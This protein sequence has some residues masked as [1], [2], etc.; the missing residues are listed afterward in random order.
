[1]PGIPDSGQEW[2]AAADGWRCH[3][4]SPAKTGE[5][6]PFSAWPYRE[7]DAPECL[8]N[9]FP[10]APTVDFWHLS[11]PIPGSV[12]VCH[13]A[14][15]APRAS[16]RRRS[17]AAL[18]REAPPSGLKRKLQPEEAERRSKTILQMAS[19]CVGCGCVAACQDCQDCQD[20]K[21]TTWRACGCGCKLASSFYEAAKP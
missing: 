16:A 10:H 2:P 8:A 6:W 19:R 11:W 21:P 4:A 15:E 1:M 13:V 14:S 12:P 3:P 18:D 20:K 17:R 5:R 7:G 9:T